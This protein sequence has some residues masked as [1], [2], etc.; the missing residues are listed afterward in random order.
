MIQCDKCFVYF[1]TH[2]DLYHHYYLE[3]QKEYEW[4]LYYFKMN[5]LYTRKRSIV[6]K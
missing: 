6:L 5:R 1:Y 3:Q 4:Y 2:R